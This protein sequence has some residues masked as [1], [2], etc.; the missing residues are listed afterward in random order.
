M[1]QFFHP[2]YKSHPSPIFR[3]TSTGQVS[4]KTNSRHHHRRLLRDTSKREESRQTTL[5]ILMDSQKF[6]VVQLEDIHYHCLLN[7]P[8]PTSTQ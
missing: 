6:R 8:Y 2:N 7:W 3:R 4:L 5:I 1:S